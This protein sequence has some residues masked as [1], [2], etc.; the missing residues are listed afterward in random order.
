MSATALNRNGSPYVD[1]ACPPW[2]CS[3]HY[4]HGWTDGL[5]YGEQG[6]GHGLN[7]GA[8]VSLFAQER[9]AEPDDESLPSTTDSPTISLHGDSLERQDMTAEHARQ[10]AAV[11]RQAADDLLEAADMLDRIEAAAA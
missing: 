5:D 2:G 10:H 1:R 11:V 4:G 9:V 6:R 3:L 8:H 7:V